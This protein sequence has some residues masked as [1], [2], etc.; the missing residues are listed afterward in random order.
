MR[1]SFA[2]AQFL[3]IAPAI[4][5]ADDLLKVGNLSIFHGRF[6]FII[7]KFKMKFLLSMSS[8]I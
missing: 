7:I 1:R 2:Q 4:L 6:I 8:E 5:S 3:R